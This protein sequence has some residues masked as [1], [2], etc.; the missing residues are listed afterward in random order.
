MEIAVTFNSV[1]RGKNKNHLLFEGYRGKDKIK[2]DYI[3]SDIESGMYD[4][5]E[6]RELAKL[7]NKDFG[8]APFDDDLQTIKEKLRTCWRYVINI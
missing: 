6:A 2:I 4:T 5:H 1:K 7:M 8:Y 3:G